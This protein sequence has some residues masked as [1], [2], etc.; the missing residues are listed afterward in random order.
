MLDFISHNKPFTVGEALAALNGC[1]VEADRVF[2]R[3]VSEH[4]AFGEVVA[5][6]PAPGT[7]L[8]PEDTITISVSSQ[9]AKRTIDLKRVLSRIAIKLSF[10]LTCPQALIE[11]SQLFRALDEEARKSSNH[12]LEVEIK[13]WIDRR[14]ELD[15]R[16]LLAS[17]LEEMSFKELANRMDT[18]GEHEREELQRLLRKDEFCEIL[19]KYFSAEHRNEYENRECRFFFFDSEESRQT[20]KW[21]N[22]SQQEAWDSYKSY[23]TSVFARLDRFENLTQDELIDRFAMARIWPALK[24]DFLALQDEEELLERQFEHE[25]WALVLDDMRGSANQNID[26]HGYAALIAKHMGFDFESI[27]WQ[28]N[29]KGVTLCLGKRWNAEDE[30]HLKWLDYL[31][32]PITLQIQYEWESPHLVLDREGLCELGNCVLW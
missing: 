32:R 13:N 6:S 17:R 29:R 26:I 25:N 14:R 11:L 5:Q 31:F 18:F 23:L 7:R 22:S 4:S 8:E 10:S 3:V 28:L 27:H 16:V 2:F 24:R 19:S 12:G 30:V 20:K 1:D 9:A 21:L 15:H